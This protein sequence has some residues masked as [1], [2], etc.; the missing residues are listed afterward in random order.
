M[1]LIFIISD[2]ILGKTPEIALPEH[3]F[4]VLALVFFEIPKM[5]LH[6]LY[7]IPSCEIG[8]KIIL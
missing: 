7:P 1:Y 8:D 2:F 3:E 6:I 4:P 5:T